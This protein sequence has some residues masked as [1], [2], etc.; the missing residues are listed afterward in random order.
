MTVQA[1]SLPA[2]DVNN[3]SVGI[4]KPRRVIHFSD[5]VLEEYSSDEEDTAMKANAEPPVNPVRQPSYNNNYH[6]MVLKG[7]YTFVN[8]QITK[9]AVIF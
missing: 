3:V 2:A 9:L 1:Q 8:Y 6:C 5:G 4:K 7:V